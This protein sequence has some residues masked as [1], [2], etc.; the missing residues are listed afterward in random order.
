MA[1]PGII[2]TSAQLNNHNSWLPQSKIRE[3]TALCQSLE[4]VNLAQ[5]FSDDAAPNELLELFS[6]ASRSKLSHQY[7]DPR[8]IAL[9]RRNLAAKLESWNAI[10]ANFE[11]EIVVTAGATEGIMSA[12]RALF[13]SGDRILTFAPVY[14]NYFHQAQVA[15]LHL[16]ATTLEE[17]EFAISIEALEKACCERTRAVLICN[18]CNP[19]GKVFSCEELEL[20]CEFARR[21]NLLIISD[22]AYEVFVWRGK[23]ISVASLPGA[24]ERTITLFSLGK[25]YSVTGWRVGYAVARPELLRPISVAHELT[26][27]SAPHPCQLA[28]AH[29]LELPASFYTEQLRQ[30]AERK[31]VLAEAATSLGI[32]P[33]NPAGAYFLWCRYSQIASEPDTTFNDRLMRSAGV[34]GVPGQVF[35]PKSAPNPRRIRLTFSKSVS[36]IREAANRLTAARLQL[37]A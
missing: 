21:H 32:E 4:A 14:E 16:D 33:W 17:P 36:T 13:Q 2:P 26:T 5:G 28:L 35:F 22:E 25:T 30:Y 12:F 20:V 9:L 31:N 15:G 29:A 19:T 6:E 7:A 11:S 10:G 8:G 37:A 27:I 18:P 23:H 3:V 24:R 34:A 1:F